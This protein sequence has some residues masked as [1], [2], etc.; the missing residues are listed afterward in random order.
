MADLKRRIIAEFSAKNKA[1]GEMAGFRRD[2]DSTGQSMMRMA[3][4]ALAMAG[5]GGGLYAAKRGFDYVTK[6][7]MKQ[8][9]AVF[10]LEAAL[11]SAGEYTAEAT[12]K[13][14]A[15]AASI[16]QATVYGD[17]EVLALM[18]LMKSLGVTS[19]KLEQATRM[20]IGLAAAT[21]RDVRSM[22]M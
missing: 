13:F 9:D 2:M 14:Q 19:N 16:Q 11:K 22:S 5:L 12:K 18:Q 15:F 20:A 10:L 4:G 3:K 21:G 1:K 17:E 7:A 6:A 8:E